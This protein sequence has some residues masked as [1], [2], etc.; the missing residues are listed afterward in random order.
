MISTAKLQ[1]VFCNARKA[2]KECCQK[3]FYQTQQYYQW[4]LK[5]KTN[6]IRRYNTAD[7]RQAKEYIKM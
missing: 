5:K 2:N 1:K 7:M 4:K 6:L 3:I